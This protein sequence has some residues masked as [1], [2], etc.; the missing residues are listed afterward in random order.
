MTIRNRVSMVLIV[1]F[2]VIAPLAGMEWQSY[3]LHCA[4]GLLVL[5]ITFGLFALGA[6]GGGDA[7]L[8]SATALWMGLGPA[9]MEYVLVAS[10]LGGLLTLSILLLRVSPKFIL[11]GA[12]RFLPHL[13]DKKIGIPYG[14][15]L[16]AAGLLTCTESDLVRW[17]LGSVNG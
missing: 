2:A 12:G 17:A 14:I 9:L 3:A 4:A 7:K 8:M 1:S 6:M 11:N 10:V 13:V 5:L 16:G 15:A